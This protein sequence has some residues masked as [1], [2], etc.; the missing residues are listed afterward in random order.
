MLQPAGER[1]QELL[2]Q[3]DKVKLQ[4]VRGEGGIGIEKGWQSQ[5]ANSIK[6]SRE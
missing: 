1:K 2:G 3:I 4:E 5:N 6:N